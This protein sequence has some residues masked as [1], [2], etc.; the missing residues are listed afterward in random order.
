MS[1]WV[2]TITQTLTVVFVNATAI[3]FCNVIGEALV[4]ELSQRQKEH[5]PEAGAKNVSLYF[6]V[7]SFGSLLTAFSSGALLEYMD[8]RK[9]IYYLTSLLNN[10]CFSAYVSVKRCALNRKESC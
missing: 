5:D 8:K 9:S 4:V 6:L 1:F 7:K 2:K 3:A 10:C